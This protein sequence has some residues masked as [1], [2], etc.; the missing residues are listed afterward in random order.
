M[1][2][3]QDTVKGMTADAYTQARIRTN[4]EGARLLLELLIREELRVRMLREEL[5]NARVGTEG[6]NQLL[7]R[8]RR[9]KAEV[10]RT[11]SEHWG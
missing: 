4:E 3:Q 10:E 6:P 2:T 5:A 8:I 9:V 1:M 7:A 11:I